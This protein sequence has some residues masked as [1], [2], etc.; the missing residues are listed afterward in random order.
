[1]RAPEARPGMVTHQRRR[2]GCFSDARWDCGARRD[3]PIGGSGR[4]RNGGD[5]ERFLLIILT[6]CSG[7][8]LVEAMD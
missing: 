5:Q 3:E 6:I 1:M 4:E 2:R 7:R 8:Q